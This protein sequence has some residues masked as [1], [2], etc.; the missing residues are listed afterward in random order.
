MVDRSARHDDRKISERGLAVPRRQSFFSQR[1]HLDRQ[2]VIG[3]I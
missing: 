1:Q 3:S 2:E